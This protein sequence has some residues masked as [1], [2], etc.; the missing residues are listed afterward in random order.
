MGGCFSLS[1]DSV[2]TQ[3]SNW[4]FAKAKIIRDLKD[5][6]PALE[7]SLVGLKAVRDDLLSRV[8][9]EERS[10]SHQRLSQVQ[11]WI[12]SADNLRNEVDDLLS[13]KEQQLQRLCIDGLCSKNP[14]KSYLFSKNVSLKLTEIE[15]LRTTALQFLQFQ[16]SV[17]EP[18][19]CFE[20][21]PVSATIVGREQ[22]LEK[23]WDHLTDD[24]VGI[25][26]LHGMGGVG[27]TTLLTQINNRL[28]RS[29][30][31]YDY[32]L[33]IVV[34]QDTDL[35]KIIDDIGVKLGLCGED[36]H[37][38]EEREK[39]IQVYNLL[40]TRRFVLFLDDIWTKV[41][42]AEIGV[43]VPTTENKC[44]IA[45][46]TRS[47]DV[48]AR[49]G[50]RDPI[51]VQC[52]APDKAFELFLKK[53]GEQT[54]QSDAQILDLASQVAE[55]CCG[56]PLALN[57]I[58]ETMASKETV[59]E[60][61]HALDVLNTYAAEFSGM[62]DI[63]LPILKF[64]YDSLKGEHI[65]SCFK[66]LAITSS[67]PKDHLIMLWISEGFID[68]SM[69]VE[70]AKNEGHAVVEILVRASLVISEFGD[71]GTVEL[72]DVIHDL[73]VWLLS[74]C[75]KFKNKVIVRKD[76]S[77]HG[78][79]GLNWET[80]TWVSV[81]STKEIDISPQCPNLSTLLLLL[82]I[83]NCSE[84]VLSQDFFR[85]MERLTVLDVAGPYNF[86]EY[87]DMSW[88][89][90]LRSLSFRSTTMKHLPIS[91]LALTGLMYLNLKS[92]RCWS[93]AGI[94][95]LS[96]LKLLWLRGCVTK[97]YISIVEELGLL[98]HL[99][100]LTISIADSACLEKL[101]SFP[102]LANVTSYLTLEHEL[103]MAQG[104]SMVWN[105]RTMEKLSQLELSRISTLDIKIVE[106]VRTG[107]FPNLTTVT[108]TQICGPADLSW[109]IYATKLTTL[110]IRGSSFEE[111]ISREQ[112]IKAYEEDLLPFEKL[113][114]LKLHF[115]PNLRSICPSSLTFPFLKELIIYDCPK[116]KR[117]PLD[118]KSIAEGLI[119]KHSPKAWITK[120]EWED[121]ATRQ[122]FLP[123]CIGE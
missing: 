115:L 92:T 42:L 25:V 63:I 3:F 11:V 49:M 5:N 16:S 4:G 101:L 45:F 106:G 33:W 40:R 81:V 37:S 22:I 56:L 89:V 118:S 53:V 100:D 109:L 91:L 110:N 97:L 78:M 120:I 69:G 58:G 8:E 51:Y 114:T 32:V 102:R 76:F 93:L 14:R 104:N 121:E 17:T 34:S 7:T 28:L 86:T 1:C 64:S 12:E 74:D 66:Y 6:I 108:M 2:V 24:G 55:R 36:W 84:T 123:S 85:Y 13:S 26:G 79:R 27:K 30:H 119:L 68:D 77:L 82:D 98:E 87:P 71:T 88:L 116:L 38:R 50:V 90:S 80:V 96:G 107:C 94:S 103:G 35:R 54:L 41:D 57:V 83:H 20:E 21:R 111:L 31:E 48:C 75:G 61:K 23:A 47:L 52:L 62:E 122:R 29:S 39:S 72:H 15:T 60:W 44:K 95:K 59:Q 43:P 105:V 46:T 99:E 19:T 9:R 112:L 73:A 117:L 18:T 113:K 70:R 67:C 10:G 65:K